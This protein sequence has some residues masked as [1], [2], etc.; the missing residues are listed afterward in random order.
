[1]ADERQ[2]LADSPTSTS[3]RRLGR[4]RLEEHLGQGG[5]GDVWTARAE[6]GADPHRLFVIKTMKRDL[7]TNERAVEMFLREAKLASRLQ[8]PHIV[9][10]FELGRDGGVYFIAMEFLDGLPWHDIAQRYWRHGKTLPLEVIV[11]SC[12]EA[13][14]ALDY[15]HTLTDKNGRHLGIVHR[16]VSPDNLFLMRSGSTKILDFGIAK[17]VSL[18]AT[19]LTEK[20][21]LR[22]KLPY[23]PPE[24]VK[25]DNVDGRADIWALGVSMFYLSTAQR[26]FDRDT[27]LETMNAILTEKAISALEMNPA[28]PASFASVIDGCLCKAPGDRFPSGRVLAETLEA[29][30][31]EVVDD[32]S[33]RA[34]LVSA[35][36][37][38]RGDR[39]PL[40]AAPSAPSYSWERTRVSSRPAFLND[41]TVDGGGV[42][43]EP[44][45]PSRPSAEQSDSGDSDPQAAGASTL[46][47]APDHAAPTRTRPLPPPE[48][49]PQAREVRASAADQ[50]Q[51][52]VPVHADVAVKVLGSSL[53][54]VGGAAPTGPQARVGASFDRVAMT[55]LMDRPSDASVVLPSPGLSPFAVGA[56]AFV[57]TLVFSLAAFVLLGLIEL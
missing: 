7:M 31:P 38:A 14:R 29:L 46:L 10:T 43:E 9:Q 40:A 1:M 34:V 11:R 18:D 21:E 8:H 56:L 52:A 28:L 23:M 54:G 22:G 32:D 13:A 51:Q 45:A 47:Q 50:G 48:A 15:A 24:Q 42:F 53:G 4:Y 26:P 12:A 16:D 6:Q 44:T 57:A 5:M 36:G 41:D 35:E 17:A 49:A 27:P 3:L 55:E 37:L 33:A 2:N 30:L 25:T 20:G 19:H 39:R